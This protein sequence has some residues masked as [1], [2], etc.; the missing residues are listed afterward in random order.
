M[1]RG[2]Q[3]FKKRKIDMS[4]YLRVFRLT[5][6]SSRPGELRLRS[7]RNIL[8]YLG[9]LWTSKPIYFQLSTLFALSLSNRISKEMKSLFQVSRLP[10]SI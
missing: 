5:D 9:H 6:L 10:W 4:D 8:A 3:R 2:N 7:W 1:I